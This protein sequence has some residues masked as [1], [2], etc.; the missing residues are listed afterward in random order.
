[1]HEN[2]HLRRTKIRKKFWAEVVLSPESRDPSLDGEADIPSP[3]SPR[4]T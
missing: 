3:H 1:M 4:L 2:T